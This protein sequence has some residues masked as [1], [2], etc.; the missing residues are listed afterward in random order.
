MPT[1]GSL[2]TYNPKLELTFANTVP[3]AS[4]EVSGV[5]ITTPEALLE[6]GVPTSLPE[7]SLVL[8]TGTAAFRLRGRITVV[9]GLL[10]ER[11]SRDACVA[12]AVRATPGARQPFPPAIVDEAASR[13]IHLLMT[14]ASA[15]TWEGTHEDIQR[16]RLLSAERR[17][18]ELSQLVHELPSQLADPRAMQ[19]IAQWIARVLDAQVLVSELASERALAAAPD[20]AAEQLAGAIIRQAVDGS[21][22]Q[23]ASGPHTQLIPL[24]PGPGASTVLA[25]ARRTSFDSADLRLLRHAAKLLGLVDQATREYRVAS[26]AA[27]AARSAAF[28]L[29]VDGEV[30]KARRVM[31][32]LA[33]GLLETDTACVFVIETRA[34]HQDLGLHR[35]ME[36]IGHQSLIVRDEQNDR[37]LL[38]VHPTPTGRISRTVSDQLVHL[39]RALGPQTSL[40]GSGVYAMGL[41]ANALHEAITVQKFAALQPN[42][43][44]LSVHDSEFVALL[45]Q[46]QAQQ[47]ANNLLSPLMGNSAQWDSMRATLPTALALPHTVAARRLNLHRNTV[48][49]RVQRAGDLLRVNLAAIT[50]QIAVALAF[51]LI[52]HRDPA[53]PPSLS[54][55]QSTLTELLATPPVKAWAEVLLQAAREDRRDLLATADAWLRADTHVEPAAHQLKLSEVTVRSH[56]KALERYTQRDFSTLTGVRDLVFSL[57][58][59]LRRPLFLSDQHVPGLQEV[60]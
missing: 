25:V 26:D 47:W 14:S 7:G 44:A 54:G 36:V 29:L 59:T 27:R 60:A 32:N 18:S 48:H 30:A 57:H 10:L 33:P 35:C 15:E 9:L 13:G 20:T 55:E 53:V 5:F 4:E 31:A 21:S 41:L 1:L 49:R 58:A 22:A 56:L 23:S 2:L 12:L 39:V 6:G 19:R 37:R 52:S 46:P 24:A 11:M 8:I 38:I 43:V 17:A 50:N 45:P 40:G 51:E 34:G 16:M 3:G 28:E 42:S